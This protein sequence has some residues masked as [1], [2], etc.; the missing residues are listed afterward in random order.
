MLP[1]VQR[2]MRQKLEALGQCIPSAYFRQGASYQCRQPVNQSINH[3]LYLPIVT[4]LENNPYIQTVI[5]IAT[6]I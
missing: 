2:S 4:N 1:F 3:F 5:W 6:K